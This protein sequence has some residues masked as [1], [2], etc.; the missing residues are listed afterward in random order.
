MSKNNSMKNA[1]SVIIAMGS[2]LGYRTFASKDVLEAALITLFRRGISQVNRSCWWKSKAW[3]DPSQ[4]AFFNGVVTA[5]TAL[6]PLELMAL[7]L[8]IEVQFGRERNQANAPRPLD[9]DLIAYEDFVLDLPGLILPHP[10]AAERRFVM[11][12]LAEIAPDWV[13]PVLNQT[14]LYLSQHALVGQ[15]AAPEAY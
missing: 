3:P 11:G 8:D 1:F 12:P 13:H 6:S 10:R 2:N 15:D 7:L 9:L 14:A 5:K 4:P